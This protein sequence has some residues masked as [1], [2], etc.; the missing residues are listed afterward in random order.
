[1]IPAVLQVSSNQNKKIYLTTG[2]GERDLYS[3]D[4][5]SGFTQWRLDLEQNNYQFSTIS[6]FASG[7]P[8]D[9]SV[10]ITIGP[11][12]DFLPEE[13]DEL[14]KFLARGGHF[15][16]M[17]DPYDSPSLVKFLQ[18]YHIDFSDKIV[19][20]PTYRL[21]QGEILTARMPL[22]SDTSPITRTMTADAVFSLARGIFIT[23]DQG[24]TAPDGLVLQQATPFLRSSHESWA[25]G[26]PKAATTGITDYQ[27]GRDTK[28]PIDVGVELDFAPAGKHI[29]VQQMTR[30]VA[31]GS[32]VFA[33]NQFFEMLGD[34]D[35]AVSAVNEMAGDEMLIASRER[36]NEG[37]T[38]GFYVSNGQ[39]NMLGYLGALGETLLM[40]LI[41]T[42]VYM[43]RRFFA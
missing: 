8:D 3:T 24:A 20:D 11:E 37:N 13:L 23:G 27:E 43:R 25:S 26:D 19:V 28:G 4:K 32:S 16:V 5:N 39:A 18:Q 10:L 14:Q 15:I 6:L 31:L 1:L 29:P 40:M 7:V 38:E 12:K 35:L 41:A 2:H 17:L 42:A 33:S 30:I 22:K 34:R 9:A 21:T 36:F